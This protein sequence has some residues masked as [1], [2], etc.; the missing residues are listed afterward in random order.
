MTLPEWA[1]R[2]SPSVQAV[3]LPDS[4]D[5]SDRSPGMRQFLSSREHVVDLRSLR[6]RSQIL[7]APPGTFGLDTEALREEVVDR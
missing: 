4:F 7:T 1:S 2:M 3:P 6:S 5:A